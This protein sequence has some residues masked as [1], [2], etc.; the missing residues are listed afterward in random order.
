MG[1]SIW[2]HIRVCLESVRV[3]DLRHQKPLREGFKLKGICDTVNIQEQTL[4]DPD[5]ESWFVFYFWT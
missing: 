3:P 5:L 1:F 2:A 4:K